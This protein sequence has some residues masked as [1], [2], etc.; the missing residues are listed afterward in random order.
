[1]LCQTRPERF[2]AAG[3]IV[4]EPFAGA[5]SRAVELVHEAVDHLVGGSRDVGVAEI[6]FRL[7]PNVM[8][9]R[10]ADLVRDG[11]RS[12]RHPGH[13]ARVFDQP[14]RHAVAE[15][16]QTFVQV[17]REDAAGEE[18]AAVV[19]DDRRL[20]DHAHVVERRGERRVAG[21]V[22]ADDLDQRHLLHRRE[23]MDPDE[24]FGTA[25]RCGERRDRQGRRIRR[26]DRALG[27]NVFRAPRDVGLDR[28]VFEHRFDDEVGVR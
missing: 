22:A 25:A 7:Q 2:A 21:D 23:E 3:R 8:A 14:R 20:A 1:M 15:Q 11:E 10:K 17:R 6:G 13:A 26:D 27:Q 9:Q 4:V 24:L 19:D 12:H 18:P 5:L 28:A 16:R